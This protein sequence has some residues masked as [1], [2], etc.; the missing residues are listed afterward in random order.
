MHKSR[1]RRRA[2]WQKTIT[3]FPSIRF[4]AEVFF[5]FLPYRTVFLMDRRHGFVRDLVPSRTPSE[6]GSV[7]WPC[8]GPNKLFRFA[9]WT[10]AP[11]PPTALHRTVGRRVSPV[12]AG[13]RVS[14]R[15]WTADDDDG[16]NDTPFRSK[17]GGLGCDIDVGTIDGEKTTCREMTGVYVSVTRIPN[18]GAIISRV[19]LFIPCCVP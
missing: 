8:P 19:C 10:F 18:L 4:P 14:E 1:V 2:F 5:F 3:F 9:I 17:L 7:P 16:P 6:T 11:A 13:P 15:P 12:F